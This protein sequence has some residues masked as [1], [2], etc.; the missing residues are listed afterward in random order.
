MTVTDT[1]IAERLKALPYDVPPD[2]RPHHITYMMTVADIDT[3]EKEEQFWATLM[4]ATPDKQREFFTAA[5]ASRKSM[6]SLIWVFLFILA[7]VVLVM[8]R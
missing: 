3:P 5:R 2:V 4:E 6:Q 1:E 8:L 7:F